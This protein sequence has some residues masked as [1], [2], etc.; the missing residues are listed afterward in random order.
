M[1]KELLAQQRQ[2]I[3]HYFDRLDLKSV[4][5]A[6]N[7]CLQTKGLIVITGVGKSGIIAEKIAMTLI[8]TGTKALS[9]PPT[10]FLHGDIGILSQDDL[11]VMIS[12]SGETEELL[13]LIPFARQRN[14]RLMAIVSN[15]NSRLA[16]AADLF[17]DLPVEKELCPFDLAPTTST[18]VQLLFGDLL[19]A[20]LMRAKEFNISDFALNHPSGSLG[21]KMTLRVEDVMLHGSNIPV[22]SPK[23]RLMDVLVELSNKKCGALLVADEKQSFLGIF[24][25]GD[26]RRALQSQG[27]S[28]L[29]AKMEVLMTATAISIPNDMLAWEALKTMQKNPKKWVMVVP[30]LKE[31]KVVGILR[32]HDIIQSGVA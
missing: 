4:E 19:A 11:F 16:K 5:A 6:L 9:L 18:S 25:D 12:K 14:T 10:N 21:K 13:D 15:R 1:L 32:I 17:V 29:E 8:S 27:P 24:T 7:A 31:C 3:Q 23:D 30:V 28:V 2:H 20:A 22:C 26:L